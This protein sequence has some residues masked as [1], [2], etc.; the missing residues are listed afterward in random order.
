VAGALK[1]SGVDPKWLQVEIT[2]SDFVDGRLS[3]V[4]SLDRLGLLGVNTAID[5]FGTGYSALS[6]LRKLTCSVLKI[7]QSFVH[8]IDTDP[9]A[10]ALVR[11]IIDMAHNLHMGVVAEGVETK[12]QLAILRGF[13]CDLIQGYL[14]S[15]PIPADKFK[16]LLTTGC[17]EVMGIPTT[18]GRPN[19]ERPVGEKLVMQFNNQERHD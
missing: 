15:R 18:L 19:Q 17:A 11:S 10:A 7:D 6:Y 14:A 16:E 2:E 3:T 12:E 13:G 9:K 8:D 5:D 1:A 4:E